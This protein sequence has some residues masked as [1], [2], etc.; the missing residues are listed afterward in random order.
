MKDFRLK[1]EPVGFE[2]RAT[3]RKSDGINDK[4]QM[5][6]YKMKVIINKG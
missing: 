2:L 6:L 4:I 5:Q 3:N 1:Q